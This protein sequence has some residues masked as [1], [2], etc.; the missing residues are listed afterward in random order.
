M[1][2]LKKLSP[3][4]NL[5]NRKIRKKLFGCEV[6]ETR[7]MLSVDFP[8]ACSTPVES[9]D[10]RP[11]YEVVAAEN[12][13]DSRSFDITLTEADVSSNSVDVKQGSLLKWYS[14]TESKILGTIDQI[15]EEIGD[16]F[17]RCWDSTEPTSDPQTATATATLDS[18]F[19]VVPMPLENVES[20]GNDD[21]SI[22]Y[23]SGGSGGSSSGGSGGSSSG[24]SGSGGCIIAPVLSGGTI[25][26]E[27]DRIVILLNTL[28]G[29]STGVVV[30]ASVGGDVN[31]DDLEIVKNWCVMGSYSDELIL[32]IV[33]DQCFEYDETMTI[34]LSVAGNGILTKTSFE[35]TIIDAPEFVSSYNVNDPTAVDLDWVEINVDTSSIWGDTIDGES[36]TQVGVYTPVINASHQVRYSFDS[37]SSTWSLDSN[38]GQV[39]YNISEGT[40][41]GSATL[42][43]R[44]SYVDYS[45]FYDT[46]VL[47]L[48][49]ADVSTAK[50]DAA[51]IRSNF[52]SS[53]LNFINF[54]LGVDT[55]ERFAFAFMEELNSQRMNNPNLNMAIKGVK[56]ATFIL[57]DDRPAWLQLSSR[58][59]AVEVT[60]ID[61]T[62]LYYDRGGLGT[63]GGV[64]GPESIPEY[65]TLE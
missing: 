3:D 34:T 6:L 44:G 45:Q 16:E 18:D 38:T 53:P 39:S 26:R 31:S 21:G 5:R 14:E 51:T 56:T 36:V 27:G 15:V 46:Q 17:D 52:A 37:S 58:H 32:V 35:V 62:V 30:T 33:D 2:F 50:T 11:T 20:Q 42:T 9:D 29:D 54:H 25:V 7:E 4:E 47:N 64:F 22:C 23:S 60:Y 57:D 10:P 8:H 28:E 49:W 43:L 59:T 41:Y 61:G 12:I 55:C 13:D 65:A 19:V 40:S 1:Q 48:R 24:G 63:F